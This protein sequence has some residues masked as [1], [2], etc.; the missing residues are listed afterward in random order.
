MVIYLFV[1]WFDR[2]NTYYILGLVALFPDSESFKP[3]LIFEA[4]DVRSEKQKEERK[5]SLN[6]FFKK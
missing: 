1:L 6:C 2:S 4:I 3:G 5:N